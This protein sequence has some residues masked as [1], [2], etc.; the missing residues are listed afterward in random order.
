MLCNE[1]IHIWCM[2]PL[3]LHCVIFTHFSLNLYYSLQNYFKNN[4]YSSSVQYY[5]LKKSLPNIY[6]HINDT[7]L[8]VAKHLVLV[9]FNYSTWTITVN[10][11]IIYNKY[12]V[13]LS[14]IRSLTNLKVIHLYIYVSFTLPNLA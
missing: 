2:Y 9:F 11:S 1:Y 3:Y 4:L 10:S 14:L 13:Y 8:C 7:H 12:H 5:H 6:L